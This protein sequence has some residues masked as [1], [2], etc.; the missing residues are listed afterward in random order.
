MGL[1]KRILEVFGAYKL[2]ERWLYE[3]IKNG[4]M[5]SHI[6]LIL[7]GN[8]RWALER[9]FEPWEGHRYGAE[10]V[11][12]LLNWCLDLGVKI[13]TLYVFSTE[14]F[15]RSNREVEKL[16]QL[17]KEKAMQYLEDERIHKHQVRIKVIGRKDLIPEDVRIVLEKLEEATNNY[18]SF[19]INI[20]V[21]YGGRAE[22]VDATKSIA[23]KVLRGELRID[24][25]NEQVIEKHLYT[26]DLPKND[27]DLII[28]TS[29]E[30]RL[31]NFLLWQCAYS[32]LV[33]LDVYWPEFRKIDLMRA[34]RTYQ[35]RQRRLGA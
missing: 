23:S 22:I 3:S 33:F 16:F 14:N 2:Y 5:P 26:A 28:R 11:D 9:G 30:E 20:A 25:I 7:D 12:E 8:R 6:A 17:L 13:I 21:A 34:I 32:E 31:S 18:C 35:K 24:D 15:K 4:E 29:G 19:F 1:L 10:K 27:P